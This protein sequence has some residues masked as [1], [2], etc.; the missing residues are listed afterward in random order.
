MDNADAIWDRLGTSAVAEMLT[1]AN[2]VFESQ[3]V[4]HFNCDAYVLWLHEC[5]SHSVF[6]LKIP[7]PEDTQSQMQYE[8][9]EEEDEEEEGYFHHKHLVN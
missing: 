1:G 4:V 5:D 3:S 6:I 8:D 7:V 2:E 9:A